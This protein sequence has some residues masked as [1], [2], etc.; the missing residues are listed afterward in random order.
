MA[1]LPPAVEIHRSTLESAGPYLVLDERFETLR[2][3]P[4]MAFLAPRYWLFPRHPCGSHRHYGD[5]MIKAQIGIDRGISSA[6]EDN[7]LVTE[8]QAD[9]CLREFACP[10]ESTGPETIPCDAYPT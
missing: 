7:D 6:L 8:I 4:G 1:P 3:G 5:P 10:C 9:R 2:L